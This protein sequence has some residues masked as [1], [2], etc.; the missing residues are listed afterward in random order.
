LL[1]AEGAAVYSWQLVTRFNSS[2]SHEFRP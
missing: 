2:V 1:F